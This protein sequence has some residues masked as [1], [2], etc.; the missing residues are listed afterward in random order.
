MPKRLRSKESAAIRDGMK[1]KVPSQ[2]SDRRLSQVTAG[3]AQK[4]LNSGEIGFHE[5]AAFVTK[6]VREDTSTVIK[7]QKILVEDWEGWW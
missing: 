1:R 7:K 5:K 6:K 4:F 2:S 3:S